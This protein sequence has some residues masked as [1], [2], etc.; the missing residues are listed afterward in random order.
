MA[1]ITAEQ[2]GGAERLAFLDM[3]AYSEIGPELLAHS[4]DGYN[5]L[6]GSTWDQPIL[7]KS[8]AAHPRILNKALDS[9]AAGRYQIIWPTWHPLQVRLGLPDI[10]PESQDLAGIE[11]VRECGALPA[12]DMGDIHHAITLCNQT[13][14]S[15]PGAA[16]LLPDGTPQHENAFGPLVAAYSAALTGYRRA[17]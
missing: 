2:A 12:I 6:V 4:D 16:A 14:A 5:V 13:W 15:L 3:L 7:F 1:R 8:Y 9:T 17:V 11:L 10:G